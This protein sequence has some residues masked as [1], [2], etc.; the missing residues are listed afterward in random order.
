M[1]SITETLA[2]QGMLN[3]RALL[4]AYETRD[5][6][7]TYLET[8]EI[9]ENGVAGPGTPVTKAFVNALLKGFSETFVNTPSG[10]MEKN[11]L[12]ADSRPGNEKYI[13]Y[14]MPGKRQ[15]TFVE[16]LN[17][18]DGDYMMP[19]CIYVVKNGNLYVYAFEGNE[20]PSENTPLLKGP[21]FN[22]Y[23]DA[24]ICLGNAKVILPENLTWKALEQAWEDLFW[25]STN[26]HTMTG[27]NPVKGN[28]CLIL[29]EQKDREEFDTS[30]LEKTIYKVKDLYNTK[31]S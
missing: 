24:K 25:N 30:L 11:I 13:W 7:K 1:E 19:G 4:V 3:P 12:F 28:L 26:S 21:F 8:H 18:E 23:A 22:Y 29:K 31:M 20:A 15:Q 6:R 14:T 9:D 16:D 27:H 17:M 10:V 5:E 2:L